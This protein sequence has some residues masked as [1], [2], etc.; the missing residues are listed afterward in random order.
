MIFSTMMLLVSISFFMYRE[1]KHPGFEEKKVTLY[2]YS[3]MA[4]IN[5]YTY[6]KP[7]I[8][9]DTESIGEG[10]IYITE[11]V[12]YIEAS[13]AYEFK[14]DEE[15]DIK[16]D[17]EVIAEVEGFTGE[18]DAYTSIWRKQFPLLEKTK[19]NV[20]DKTI[21][22]KENIQLKLGEYNNFA[23][24][25]IEDSKIV[26][27]VKL[28][29]L[30]NINLNTDTEKG[31]IKDKISPTMIIPLNTNYFKIRGNLVQEKPGSIEKTNQIQLPINEK[32]MKF[33]GVIIGALLLLLT[34][35]I[36][37]TNVSAMADPLEKKLKKIFKNHGDR[38]VALNNEVTI[39]C[40]NY[41]MV[42]SIDDLVRIADEIGKPIIYKHSLD[43]KEISKFY[44][45]DEKQ[46][47]ILDLTQVLLKSDGNNLQ[48]EKVKSTNDMKKLRKIISGLKS[49]KQEKE[50]AEIET[51]E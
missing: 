29:V 24:K 17:Y 42:K 13:L 39:N 7:N 48:K 46:M 31:I 22:I 47:Y 4:S 20:K 45:Y 44:V 11:F 23:K 14:G 33:Y 35:I 16:G 34:Y 30:M 32:K 49:S 36:I 37:F 50:E 51:T 8:L 43:F 25:V 12:D 6:L 1:W 10:H 19:F 3:N 15:A 18:G 40:E 41:S 26:S 27:N 28:T 38:L 5:Y 21:S 2:S 9:Y